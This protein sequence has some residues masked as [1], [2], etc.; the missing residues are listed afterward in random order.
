MNSILASAVLTASILFA[1]QAAAQD[2]VP[3]EKIKDAA[4]DGQF[5]KGATADD[6]AF[7]KAAR[8]AVDAS[9]LRRLQKFIIKRRLNSP[10]FVEFVKSEY[11]AEQYWEDP[12]NFNAAAIDWDN[13][14]WAK[15]IDLILTL[16]KI[17]G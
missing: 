9:D 8:K 2:P 1:G 12:D 5:F 15:L 7:I 10:R 4:T 17:F 3:P 16:I 11:I 13:I 14:D 6:K